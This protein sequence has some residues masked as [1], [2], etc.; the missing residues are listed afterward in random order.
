MPR[1]SGDDAYAELARMR[2]DAYTERT[3]TQREQESSEKAGL[4]RRLARARSEKAFEDC[5]RHVFGERHADFSSR[6]RRDLF[7]LWETGLALGPL[8]C[9]AY[10]GSPGPGGFGRF[11][12]ELSYDSPP[13]SPEVSEPSEPQAKAKLALDPKPKLYPATVGKWEPEWGASSERNCTRPPCPSCGGRGLGDYP[14]PCDTCG[15]TGN[16]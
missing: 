8:H 9:R 13:D 4:E 11:P 3:G 10:K 2:D 1:D 5:L 6:L 15:G 12:P 16:G 14:F 7:T